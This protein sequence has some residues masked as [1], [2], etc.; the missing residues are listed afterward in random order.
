MFTCVFIGCVFVRE[1]VSRLGSERIDSE[2]VDLAHLN[3]RVYYP[4]S[5]LEPKESILIG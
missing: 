2:S 3:S 4:V 5:R 1:P